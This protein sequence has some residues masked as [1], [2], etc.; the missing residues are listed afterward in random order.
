MG[1]FINTNVSSLNA[2]INLNQ[3]SQSLRI[4]QERLSSGLR[5]NSAK[6]DAAGLA[7]SD[8]MTA[9]I[10]GLNQAARNANDGISLAQTAEGALQESTNILQR[11]RELAVQ[12]ANDTNSADDRASLQAEVDQLISEI[13]RIANTTSFNNKNILDGTLSDA[14]F[15]VGANANQTISVSIDDARANTLGSNATITTTGVTSTGTSTGLSA[16]TNF[17]INGVTISPV[18]DGVSVQDGGSSALS[19]ANAINDKAALSGVSAKT[20]STEVNIGTISADSNGITGDN[21][22]IN[23]VQIEV[24]SISA[25]DSNGNLRDAINAVSNQTGVKAE[26][27]ES[28]ELILTAE[29]GRNIRLQTDD[30]N[31]TALFSVF[32]LDP[33]TNGTTAGGAVDNIFTGNVTFDSDSSFVISNAGFTNTTDGQTLTNGTY[34]VDTTNSI[35]NTDISTQ[36]GSNTAITNI[37]RAIATIDSIRVDLGGVRNRLE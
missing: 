23:D 36:S 12:S 4:N 15:H 30:T 34:N 27:N 5:I 25:N 13:D 33:S 1:L 24:S 3:S 10:R 17:E 11:M 16:L 7:I 6:D 18:D 9:Q 32:T 26:L 29:D 8:R 28:N 14:I 22:E 19:L 35:A 20:N 2:Q 37:D 31:D 21:F